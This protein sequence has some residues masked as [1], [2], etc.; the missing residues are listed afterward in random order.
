MDATLKANPLVTK[1]QFP[2]SACAD[3]TARATA[4]PAARPVAGWPEHAGLPG[5]RGDGPR[6]AHRRSAFP[7]GTAARRTGPGAGPGDQPYHRVGRDRKSTRLNSSH[8]TISY[9]VFCLK[10]KKTHIN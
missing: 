5:P 8:I 6:S 3:R 2:G 9:A 4:G 7:G 1:S 10:K